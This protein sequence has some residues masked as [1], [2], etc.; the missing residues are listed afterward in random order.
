MG[1]KSHITLSNGENFN[2]SIEESDRLK[3]LQKKFARQ[4]KKSNNRYKTKRKIQI[5]YQKLNN[6]KN[7]KA[8]KIVHEIRKYKFIFMQ[9]EN[10]TSWHQDKVKKFSKTIQNSCLG[11]VKA[12]LLNEAI[13]LDSYVPTSKTCSNCG[14]IN[15]NLK[16]KDREFNCE[17]CHYSI[18]RDL[19]AA[20][21]MI[22]LAKSGNYKFKTVPTEY[23]KLVRSSDKKP[24]DHF[25]RSGKKQEDH[26]PLG[27]D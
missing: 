18:N 13:I 17:Q 21:N 15:E 24:V 19:N 10:L 5:E 23:R 22:K 9:D 7:D 3:R 16:L 4:D 26:I 14:F 6:K 1:I 12:K 25:K 2:C 20:F 27:C 11:R 8:N